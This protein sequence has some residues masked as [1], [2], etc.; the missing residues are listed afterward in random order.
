MKR[1]ELLA[2]GY[3]EEQVT[4]LLNTFHSVNKENQILK[5]ELE[6]AS[7]IETKY[8]ELQKQLDDINK[9]KMS[10]QERLE[11]EKKEIAKNLRESKIIVNK[12]K[13]KEILAGLDIDDG[14]IDTLVNEDETITLNN[15]NLLKNK[16]DSFKETVAKQTKESIANIDVKPTQTNIPQTSDKMT[17]EKYTQLSQEEQNRFAIENPTEFA[18]L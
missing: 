1:E 12:A 11:E 6:N 18:N 8:K 2:K 14:L 9:A 16:F 3:T 17:W 15:A 5:S 7:S 13:A 4:D 10:D